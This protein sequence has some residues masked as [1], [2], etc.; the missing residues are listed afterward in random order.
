M[1]GN[2]RPVKVPSP[3]K[4]TNSSPLKIRIPSSIFRCQL[5]V[6]FRECIKS[7]HTKNMS[8]GLQ[9]V[10]VE[11]VELTKVEPCFL[12]CPAE[13]SDLV[14]LHGTNIS[15]FGK[16]KIIDSKVPLKG[17]YVSSLEAI[18]PNPSKQLMVKVVAVTAV[19]AVVVAMWLV[20]KVVMEEVMLVVCML[21]M[22]VVILEVKVTSAFFQQRNF[23]ATTG[24]SFCQKTCE[25]LSGEKVAPKKIVNKNLSRRAPNL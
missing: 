17:G 1:A 10:V 6:S 15:H 9:T 25:N 14:T 13:A 4:K 22:L 8:V 18:F 3:P 7:L 19:L 24:S 5:A 20:V 12:A 16:R 23:S 21:P 11:L 2:S